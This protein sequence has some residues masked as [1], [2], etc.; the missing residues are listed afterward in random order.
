[1]GSDFGCEPLLGHAET[2]IDSKPVVKELGQGTVLS[3]TIVLASSAIGA[4]IL[5]FPYAFC[6]AG[7][8]SALI[9]L[10]SITALIYFALC[11]IGR[12]MQV[13]QQHSPSV[14]SYDELVQAT[15]GPSAAIIMELV[16]IFFMLG[17]CVGF[18]T[19]IGDMLGPLLASDREGE[20]WLD[21]STVAYFGGSNG[22]RRSVL[23]AV[24]LGLCFPLSLLR[25]LN[26]LRFTSSLSISSVCYLVV[27]LTAGSETKN[28]Q[29]VHFKPI[30]PGVVTAIPIMAFALQCHISAPLVYS[31]MHSSIKG[32]R[33]MNR[34]SFMAM[35]LCMLL[36]IPA[37][38]FGYIRFGE[39]VLGDVLTLGAAH[40]EADSSGMGGF[41]VSN[42]WADLARVCTSITAVSGYALNH[43]PARP[44][45]FSMLNRFQQRAGGQS[46][47]DAIPTHLIFLEASVWLGLCFI[48]AV[49]CTNL[50]AVFSITG[51]TCGSMVI[52]ILPGL[53]W[54]HHGPK[55]TWQRLLPSTVLWVVGIAIILVGTV[56][57]LIQG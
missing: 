40:C 9:I 30:W 5:S 46:Y 13:V 29:V 7:M 8:I 14:R 23:L 17:T 18:L 19:I 56:A 22:V 51:A 21:A 4:G 43:Y 27:L 54:W 26:A 37:G 57:T 38:V 11:V 2:G 28:A 41:A 35:A 24:A 32:A 42:A 1:M 31:E 34:V 10:L 49:C 16:I 45:I 36:Y 25:S 53:F 3:S 47:Q 50:A 52:F 33:W 55:T 15:L 20:G 44:A 39:S 48:I 6:R 12:A